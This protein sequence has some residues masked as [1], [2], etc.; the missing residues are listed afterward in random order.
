VH[1]ISDAQ[2]SQ[3]YP[4]YTIKFHIHVCSNLAYDQYSIQPHQC[5]KESDV[6]GET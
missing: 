5:S 1:A 4:M 3:A 6:A 2:D